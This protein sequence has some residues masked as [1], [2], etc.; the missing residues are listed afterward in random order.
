MWVAGEGV[1]DLNP[2]K[3]DLCS[4]LSIMRLGWA[5]GRYR[6]IAREGWSSG[7]SCSL[8]CGSSSF[9]PNTDILYDFGQVMSA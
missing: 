3:M 7:K 8:G 9:N 5:F 2:K 1:T 6:H 4:M